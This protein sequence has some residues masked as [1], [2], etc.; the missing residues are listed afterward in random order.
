MG[1]E[2]CI[3]DSLVGYEEIQPLSAAERAAFPLLTQTCTA[4][5]QAFLWKSGK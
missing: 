1:S 5:Y 2:M 4:R 3:R